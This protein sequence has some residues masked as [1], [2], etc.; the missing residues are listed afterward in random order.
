MRLLDSAGSEVL[1]TNPAPDV[2]EVALTVTG[3]YYAEVTA[4][5]GA[6]TLAR[7][8]SGG[9]GDGSGA[10]AGGVGGGVAGRGHDGGSWGGD[11][12]GAGERV[13]AGRD[14]ES[15]DGGLR[16]A[17]GA[18]VHPLVLS[19]DVAGGGGLG[20]VAGR[21]PGDGQRRGGAGVAV[22]AVR[23]RGLLAGSER[24]RGG[25]HVGVEQRGGGELHA[26]GGR[27]AEFRRQLRR[28]VPVLQ[29]RAVV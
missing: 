20:G 4:L 14:G 7:R 29:R 6:G 10:A 19:P 11:I 15:A 25:R 23:G 24:L 3:Q 21:A 16:H 9:A 22:C 27:G 1:D 2:A 26:L 17:R 8:H 13:A 28:G 18:H 12:H 5:S